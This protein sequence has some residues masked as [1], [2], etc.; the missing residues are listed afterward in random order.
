[1]LHVVAE[2]LRLGDYQRVAPVAIDLAAFGKRFSVSRSHLRRLLESAYAKGLLTRPPLNGSDVRLSPQTVA[3][4]Q[5][6][7]AYELGFYRRN[8][9]GF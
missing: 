6:C 1:L 9:V 3:A 4:F 7:M 2:S 5:N 8:A